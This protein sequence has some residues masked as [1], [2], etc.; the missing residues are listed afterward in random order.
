MILITYI[1]ASLSATYAIFQTEKGASSFNR[2]TR[3]LLTRAHLFIIQLFFT[4]KPCS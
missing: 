3:R 1:G 4:F 2:I